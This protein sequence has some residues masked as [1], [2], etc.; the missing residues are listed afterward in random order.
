MAGELRQAL[1][2]LQVKL[3]DP[4]LSALVVTTM[5]YTNRRTLYLT[6]PIGQ[7][8]ADMAV[9]R[10]FQDGGRPPSCICKS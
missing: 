4:C 3:C 8:V 1:C 6:M 9:L 10:F 5:R 7:A 2:N